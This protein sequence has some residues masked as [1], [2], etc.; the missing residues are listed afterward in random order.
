M[1]AWLTMISAVLAVFG[2]A[3][4][5][6]MARRLHWLTEK[7]DNTLLRLVIRLLLPCL[8]LDVILGNERLLAP[9]NVVLPPMV[10]LGSILLGFAVAA[11]VAALL[12]RLPGLQTSAQRRTFVFCVAVYNYEYIP[13]PLMDALFDGDQGVLGVLFVHNMGVEVAVWTVGILV[14]S[15]SL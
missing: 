7:A 1:S 12:R 4:L 2:V 9:A 13:L 11:G 14:I 3:M 8:I 15:G 6:L 5:G 10:G